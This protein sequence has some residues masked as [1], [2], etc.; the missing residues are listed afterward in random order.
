M[1]E[2]DLYINGQKPDLG[3]YVKKDAGLPDFANP[4]EWVFG[5]TTAEDFIPRDVV[6]SVAACGHAFRDVG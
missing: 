3:I 5:G 6:A 1:C 4:D 2:Y